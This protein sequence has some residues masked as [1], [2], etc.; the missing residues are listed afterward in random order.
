VV[1]NS[2][3]G[4][5]VQVMILIVTREADSATEHIKIFAKLARHMMDENFRIQ[6]AGETDTDKLCAFMQ[7][8]LQIEAA[9]KN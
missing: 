7:T 1:W 5:P 8:T 2:L 4:L 9:G 3:D 6:V